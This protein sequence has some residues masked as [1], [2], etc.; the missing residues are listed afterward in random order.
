[1]KIIKIMVSCFA[2]S[3]LMLNSACA[4]GDISALLK[5]INET[6]SQA[7]S[8][9]IATLGI[10][11]AETTTKKSFTDKTIAGYPIV[12]KVSRIDKAKM[13]DISEVIL[14]PENYSNLLQRCK[15]KTL[16]GFRFRR[17]K[18]VAEFVYSQPCMQAIW[19]ANIDGKLMT[20]GGVLGPAYGKVI[21]NLFQ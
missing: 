6:V 5:K 9:E 3:C 10:V 14:N 4:E 17:G 7:D 21:L 12:G 2:L 16:Y 1:M 13:H 19:H 11:P 20:A 15:N 8:I 18:D